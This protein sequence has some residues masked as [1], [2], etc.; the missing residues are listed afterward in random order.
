[1]GGDRLF[2][3]SRAVGNAVERKGPVRVGGQ[4]GGLRGREFLE[5]VEFERPGMRGERRGDVVGGL[6][7]KRQPKPAARTGDGRRQW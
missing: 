1:M 4:R 2:S 6:V 5:C 3:L 7:Q